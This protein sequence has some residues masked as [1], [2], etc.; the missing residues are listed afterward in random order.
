MQDVYEMTTTKGI[1]EL[2]GDRVPGVLDVQKR[3]TAFLEK[4]LS[5]DELALIGRLSLFGYDHSLKWVLATRTC[6]GCH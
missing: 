1:Q 4:T 6:P 5:P 3:Y 2:T